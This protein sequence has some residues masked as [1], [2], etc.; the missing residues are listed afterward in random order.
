MGAHIA[1]QPC[2]DLPLAE[3]GDPSQELPIAL[4]WR[5]VGNFE[6]MA[7]VWQSAARRKLRVNMG[8][9]R[10]QWSERIGVRG[11]VGK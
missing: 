6:L 4:P 7:G 2:S 11:Y 8:G 3:K 5:R 10:C 9:K 1:F